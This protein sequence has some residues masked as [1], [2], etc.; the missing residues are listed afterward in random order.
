MKTPKTL[1]KILN[2]LYLAVLLLVLL[3][4]LTDFEIKSY[5]IRLFVNYWLVTNTPIVLLCNIFYPVFKSKRRNDL[6][7]PAMLLV[8][9]LIIGPSKILS[10]KDTWETQAVLYQNKHLV[11]RKIEFQIQDAG[12]HGYYKR[13]VEVVYLTPLFVIVRPVPTDIHQN[14]DWVKVS[15]AVNGTHLSPLQSIPQKRFFH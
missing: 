14:A 7:I 6:T 1:L 12:T 5:S 10:A 8:L 2:L 9:I 4:A 15:G 11:F 13:T 3:E